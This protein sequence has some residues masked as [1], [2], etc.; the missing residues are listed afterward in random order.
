MTIVSIPLKQH[1]DDYL[2][3]Q[4]KLGKTFSKADLIRRA[5]IKYKE[6]DFVTTITTARQ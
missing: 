1:L 6:G 5:I 4:V 2:D 3:E